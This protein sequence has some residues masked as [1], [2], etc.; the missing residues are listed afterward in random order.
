MLDSAYK[1]AI[2]ILAIASSSSLIHLAHFASISL[3]LSIQH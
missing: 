1:D 2:V 3:D